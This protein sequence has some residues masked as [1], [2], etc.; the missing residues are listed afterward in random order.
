M[1][2]QGS[3]QQEMEAADQGLSWPKLLALKE[4]GELFTARF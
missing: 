4:P 1:R 3:P 2:N